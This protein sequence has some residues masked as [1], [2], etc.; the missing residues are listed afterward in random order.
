[1]KLKL[2]RKTG[3]EN[4]HPIFGIVSSVT[5]MQYAVAEYDQFGPILRLGPFA[6]FNSA[7]QAL[8]RLQAKHARAS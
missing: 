4:P 6:S 3:N 7:L 8:D 5:T 1:M 2:W